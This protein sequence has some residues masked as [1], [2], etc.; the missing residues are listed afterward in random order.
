MFV[1]TVLG[2]QITIHA[3]TCKNKSIPFAHINTPIGFDYPINCKGRIMKVLPVLSVVMD[4]FPH[5][6]FRLLLSSLMRQWCTTFSGRKSRSTETC[7]LG[8]L[9]GDR[10]IQNGHPQAEMPWHRRL[11]HRRPCIREWQ[12]SSVLDLSSRQAL[13]PRVDK[14]HLQFLL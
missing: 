2:R 14:L 10:R 1:S 13:P 7:Q 11:G 9:A 5:R 12:L 6:F 3:S 4:V 8:N